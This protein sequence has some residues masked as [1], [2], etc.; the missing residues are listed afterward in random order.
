LGANAKRLLKGVANG[1]SRSSAA[2]SG[3]AGE[4]GIASNS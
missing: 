3:L 2:T 4:E 1:A